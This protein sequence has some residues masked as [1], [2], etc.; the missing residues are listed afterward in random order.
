[1]RKIGLA[2][3]STCTT[4]GGSLPPSAYEG[5]VTKAVKLLTRQ[6][7]SRGS[8]TLPASASVT[9][10]ETLRRPITPATMSEDDVTALLRET[11]INLARSQSH[12]QENSAAA[13]DCDLSGPPPTVSVDGHAPA[14]EGTAAAAASIPRWK[15]VLDLTCI[16]VSI[17]IWLPLMLLIMLWVKLVSPGPVFYRQER[18]GHRQRR[19]M[20]FKFRTMHINAE[21]QSHEHHFERLMQSDSPMT[22]LDAAGDP[23]IIRLGRILRAAGLDELPQLFNVLGGE[24]SLIGPRPC[25]LREFARYQTCHHERFDAPPG[26]TGL[27]QTNGKNKTTFNQ[28]IGLD[29]RYAREMSLRLDLL[30]LAKTV[31]AVITQVA[32]LWRSSWA[33][34]GARPAQQKFSS[35]L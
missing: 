28:M 11:V 34:H 4:K 17:P 23:R 21:T 35:C 18:L 32:E 19:F 9:P 27:W 3:Q 31:P 33:R 12:R 8:R 10:R 20:L 6:Y 5:I 13:D 7:S 30:I 15:R 29:I 22:K 14:I 26:M 25:T 1:M 2:S 16:A 24:M